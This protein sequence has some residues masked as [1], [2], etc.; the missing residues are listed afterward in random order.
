MDC[1]Q[2]EELAGAYVLGATSELERHAAQAHLTTCAS[3]Q[4]IV[5]ELQTVTDL[6]PLAVPAVEP[7]PDLKKR[8][9]ALV[10]IDAREQTAQRA[11]QRLQLPRWWH[12]TQM[13]IAAACLLLLLILVGSL[14]AWN[15]SL[16]QEL[17]GISAGQYFH[18]QIQSTTP[19]PAISGEAL[20]FPQLHTTILTI[21]GLPL[22][23][24]TEVYQGW[25]IKNN[26]PASM[27]LLNIQ[28]GTGTLDFPGDIRT[29]DAIAV[30][31]EPGPQ[32]SQGHPHG[33]II[34]LGTLQNKQGLRGSRSQLTML[35]ERKVEE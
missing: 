30:S 10:E 15:V 1:Q 31:R 16:Q 19:N 34:A 11:T 4:H 3:C 18:Y 20:Y 35:I 12:Y 13:R 14:T 29:F 24:G 9:M 7:S 8:V 6:L 33:Q 21:Q 25:L 17:R 26:H 27:G 2:F 5:R 22:L 23:P 28:N 32:A